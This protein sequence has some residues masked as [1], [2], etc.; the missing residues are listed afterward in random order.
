MRRMTSSGIKRRAASLPT[1]TRRTR[2]LL[3]WPRNLALFEFSLL[4]QGT[5]FK[6]HT[7]S[8]T[9]ENIIRNHIRAILQ[10][11]RFYGLHFLSHTIWV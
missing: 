10:R 3:R 2:L 11:A 7:C 5:H 6:T 9:S 1:T 4:V 8:V